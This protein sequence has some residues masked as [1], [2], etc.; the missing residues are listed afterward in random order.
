[1][2]LSRN[3]YIDKRICSQELNHLSYPFLLENIQEEGPDDPRNNLP[4]KHD[5]VYLYNYN[6]K[7]GKR[8]A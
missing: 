3:L 6:A 1:M 5:E 2:D 7:P 4:P 8:P